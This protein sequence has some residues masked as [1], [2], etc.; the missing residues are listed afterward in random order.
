MKASGHVQGYNLDQ[1]DAEGANTY[2]GEGHCLVY[3]VPICGPYPGKA[4]S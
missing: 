1:R 2:I 4:R 3:S